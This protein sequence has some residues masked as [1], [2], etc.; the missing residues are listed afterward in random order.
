[1]RDDV[2]GDRA[3]QHSGKAGVAARAEDDQAGTD[4]FG[5]VGNDLALPADAD[6]RH[7]RGRRRLRQSKR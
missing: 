6:M 5:E 1:M 7:G 4:L 2:L 3:Q